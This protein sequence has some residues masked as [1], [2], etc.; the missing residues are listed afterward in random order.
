MDLKGRF[1]TFHNRHFAD[2]GQ[3][4][5]DQGDLRLKPRNR[6]DTFGPQGK[7]GI[8]AHINL[9]KL[10]VGAEK[11]EDLIL[12]QGQR[13][14]AAAARGEAYLPYHTTRMWPKRAAELLAGG[15]L[16]WVFKGFVLA[17]QEVLRLD[18][19][20]GA[21]G[22]TRC[23]IVM[24]RDIIRTQAAPRRPFQGW[25]YLTM[26]DAPPDLPK[27]RESDDELPE[28]LSLAL[29]DIGLR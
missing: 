1:G 26:E 19:D 17:R 23:R 12:W 22:I 10:C 2:L 9:V 24:S 20:L 25:R 13:T 6:R 27:G 29:A 18:E 21:D 7:G 14:K 28:G 11:V 4:I 8:V 16:Y 3:R 5:A 15:S